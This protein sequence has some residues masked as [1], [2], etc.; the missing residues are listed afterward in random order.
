[1]AYA[2]TWQISEPVALRALERPRG[3][4]GSI[5]HYRAGRK[6]RGGLG[7]TAVAA[8]AAMLTHL[9]R[10]QPGGDKHAD[11]SAHAAADKE[12][13]A[14]ANADAHANG[15]SL[16]FH[17]G[18]PDANA[19]G[20]EGGLRW[21]ATHAIAVQATAAVLRVAIAETPDRSFRF[22]TTDI[23][24]SSI[25][26]ATDQLL[27]A[28]NLQSDVHGCTAVGQAVMIPL[29]LPAVTSQQA[30]GGADPLWSGQ[31][32]A[33]LVEPVL[34]AA[35]GWRHTVMSGGLGGLGMLAAL[36]LTWQGAGVITLLGRSGRST[37]LIVRLQDLSGFKCNACKVASC[38]HGITNPDQ[39]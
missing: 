9:Q 31:G 17:A 15:D 13:N 25:S 30:P 16:L 33:D 18:M 21:Q 4:T 39:K 22:I 1:M 6:T 34:P 35:T 3:D 8:A 32:A 24:S 27:S 12:A 20:G 19:P 11:A 28:E 37:F 2:L 7:E 26:I 29:L 10:R 14:N 36:W 5:L 38:Q 23:A